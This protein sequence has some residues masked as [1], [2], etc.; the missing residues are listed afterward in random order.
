M[1]L[2]HKLCFLT[3]ISYMNARCEIIVNE[4][5]V[6]IKILRGRKELKVFIDD[7]EQD[8]TKVVCKCFKTNL[9]I[10]SMI[11]TVKCGF[12]S[13]PLNFICS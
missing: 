12:N 2:K 10:H 13:H 6:Q 7:I 1:W 8:E 9:F 11:I 4:Q 5:T 3:G